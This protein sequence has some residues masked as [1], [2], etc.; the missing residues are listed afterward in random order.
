MSRSLAIPLHE[1][2]TRLIAALHQ[3]GL[4]VIH[5]KWCLSTNHLPGVLSDVLLTTDGSVQETENTISVLSLKTFEVLIRRVQSPVPLGDSS[6]KVQLGPKLTRSVLP[7]W[8]TFPRP[9]LSLPSTCS[10]Q[11]QASH[12]YNFIIQCQMVFTHTCSIIVL[13]RC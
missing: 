6:L 2:A 9:R 5:F 3:L 7:T 12:F 1:W 11:E 13:A 8:R 4:R 10:V